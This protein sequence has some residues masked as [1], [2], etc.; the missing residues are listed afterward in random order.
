LQKIACEDAV[1]VAI[2]ESVFRGGSRGVLPKDIAIDI[3]VDAGFK[4]RAPY[5]LKPY[6]VSRRILRMNKKLLDGPDGIGECLFEKRGLG[7]ALTSFALEVWDEEAIEKE[8][9]TSIPSLG[10]S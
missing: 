1:D 7:W 8:N 4:N 2:L 6:H 5:G 3:D 10:S 9:T